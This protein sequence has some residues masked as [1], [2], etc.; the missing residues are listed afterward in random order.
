MILEAKHITHSF[1]SH[2]V[3]DDL[4]LE[5]DSKEVVGLIGGNGAGKTTLLRI[6]TRL[7]VPDSGEVL[8]RGHPIMQ[9]DMS[10]I[11]YLPEERGLYRHMKT[12]EQAIY[13]ARLKGLGKAE[14]ETA[15]DEWFERLGMQAWKDRPAGKLS[16]GMQQRLQLVVSVVHRPELLILDEP[17]TGLDSD[18]AS[19][20]TQ[21]VLRLRDQGT[22]ILLST[23]NTTAVETLCN[24]TIKL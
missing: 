9:S 20:L 23:H 4:N 11:G 19:L 18:N 13:F 1:G 22:S 12:R 21:E 14:A 24:R 16:K 3:L 8:F 6:V 17:F 7:L 5:V 10:H 2:R 15:V